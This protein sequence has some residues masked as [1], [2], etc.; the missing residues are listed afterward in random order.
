MKKHDKSLEE[1]WEWKERVYQDLKDCA[2]H[3]YIEKA[4]QAANDILSDNR[5]AL[6]R[7]FITRAKHRKAA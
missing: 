3:E 2:P 4:T 5:I 6:Q 7:V 1:V